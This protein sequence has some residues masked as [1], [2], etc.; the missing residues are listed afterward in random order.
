MGFKVALLSN[1]N[2]DFVI[3]LLD[4]KYDV[5]MPE[6]YGNELGA[7]L[8]PNSK[9]NLF[10]PNLTFI[11]M[12]VMELLNHE[13]YNDTYIKEK[14]E[15]WFINFE[16]SIHSNVI[17]YISDSYL[18]GEE[19]EV[20][21]DIKLKQNIEFIW[22][23]ALKNLCIKKPNVHIFAYHRMIEKIGEKNAFSR[24]MWYMGKILHT[25]LA[26]KEIYTQIVEDIALNNRIPRKA[27]VVDLD[28]TL[29]GGLAGENETTPITL[30]DD[31]SGLA[32]KNLQRVLK[33]MQKAGVILAISSKNNEKDAIEIIR[34]HPHM[35]LR[36]NNFSAVRINWNLKTENIKEIAKDLNIGL[37]SVVFW[38][39]S[40]TERV[41]VKQLLPEVVVPE[42][43]KNPEEL[44][45][46]MCEIY[47]QY[48]AQAVITEEDKNKARQ[49]SDNQKRKHLESESTNFKDF[50]RNLHIKAV[51]VDA[52]KNFTR[53]H[54]LLNKTNQ[55]NLMTQ[56]YTVDELAEILNDINIDVY[57]YD[58]SDCFGD[59]GLVFA[60]IVDRG[61][62]IPVI[63]DVV[64]SCR[65]MGKRVEYALIEEIENDLQ[66]K[67][68][69]SVKAVFIPTSKN[70]P[71]ENL[72]DQLGY[73]L[74]KENEDGV[75]QYLLNIFCRNKRDYFVE[76]K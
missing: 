18:F 19:L 74:L 48:F 76:V 58:V 40:P 60:A 50:L 70:K 14:I 38:D 39:D 16:N 65:V 17:Y 31:H 27:L 5:C 20:V 25:N 33:G 22:D 15:T 11:L 59:Y 10:N 36:E 44:P 47:H 21:Y 30:S 51:R 73:S 62:S 56:R 13:I 52:K 2:L 35:V 3:R 64:M 68:Y 49:Y 42:F 71:V 6:G 28:N 53:L 63:K 7:L 45:R 9:Y 1:I 54:Q 55:F 29:W 75:K 23:K 43:P 67:G 41:L 72:Y 34:N 32:F 61:G 66:A 37:D 26:L 8:N 12:D 69:D 24:K 46:M 57:L 4:K